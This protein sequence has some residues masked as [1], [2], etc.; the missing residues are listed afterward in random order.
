[1]ILFLD[2][3]GTL[4]HSDLLFM[5]FRYILPRNPL[6]AIEVLLEYCRQGIPGIKRRLSIHCAP[7]KLLLRWNEDV[8]DF[9]G[10][11]Q[12]GFSKIIVA[13][14]GDEHSVRAA[15]ADRKCNWEVIGTREGMNLK[16]LKK[17]KVMF[18]VAQSYN[19]CYVGDSRADLPIWKEARMIGFVG[20]LKQKHKYEQQLNKP[21]TYFFRVD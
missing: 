1:M 10:Q 18:E 20:T 2:F 14:A 16:G 19:F 9:A 15:L 7:Q 4:H 21:F 6:V 5:Q 3:D 13:T 8:F 17:L 12:H 11:E